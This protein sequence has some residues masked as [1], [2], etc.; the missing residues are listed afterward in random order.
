MNQEYA[1][2]FGLKANKTT[3]YVENLFAEVF[4]NI[5]SEVETVFREELLRAK[6]QHLGVYV[7]QFLGQKIY[8]S[9]Q[10]LGDENTHYGHYD[11]LFIENPSEDQIKLAN[12]IDKTKEDLRFLQQW[13]SL[14]LGIK[15]SIPP[16]LLRASN[17]PPTMYCIPEGKEETWKKAEDLITYYLGLSLVL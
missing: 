5:F 10:A 8:R 4:N 11:C 17:L 2:A 6:E 15:E 14:A 16:S 7:L 13:L 1:L 12:F 3:P 9:R